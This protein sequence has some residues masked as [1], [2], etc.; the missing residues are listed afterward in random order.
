ME[1]RK[2]VGGWIQRLDSDLGGRYLFTA[3]TSTPHTLE[4]VA[5]QN[6]STQGAVGTM[7]SLVMEAAM[8][9]SWAPSIAASLGGERVRNCEEMGRSVIGSEAM[10][11]DI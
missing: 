9:A 5:L 1:L 6:A 3:A 11:T 7:P 4:D 10:H 8:R 2:E